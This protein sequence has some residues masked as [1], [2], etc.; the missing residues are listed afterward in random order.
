MPTPAS[1]GFELWA[2]ALE[3]ARG[4]AIAAPTHMANA[5][6]TIVGKLDEY[7]P[8]DQVGELAEAQ[9]EEIVRQSATFALEGAADVT[10]M[11][12]FANLLLDAKTT[13]ILA[14]GEVTGFT[15]LTGGSGY[16]TAP[17][18]ALTAPPA[19]GR[20]AVMTA[21]V[22]AGVV[23]ALTIVDPGQGYATAPT[24]TFTPTGG[25]SGA[26]V[27]ITISARATLANMWEFTRKLT[28]DTIKSATAWWGDPNVLAWKC[29]CAM[30]NSLKLTGDASGTD[31]VKV[32]LDGIAMFP[33]ELLSGSMPT[34]PAIL[35]GPVLV[36]GRM[37]L[38]L[39]NNS[40]A[41]FGTTAITGRVAGAEITIP[42]GVTPIYIAT[43]PLGGVTFDHV[44]RKRARP[45]MKFTI[46]IQDN[47]QTQLF[48]AGT[49]CK[50]RVRFNSATPIEGAGATAFYPFVEVDMMGKLNA[51]DWGDL[52]GA[53]RTATFTLGGVKCPQIASDVR[54]RIQN[55]S[56]VL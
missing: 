44:Q 3:A 41:P 35:L 21:T 51:L 20:Q 18:V 33:S 2:L 42:T 4:T 17:T 7:V 29:A 52:E 25:G 32:A 22:A 34:W 27:T 38:W 55:S 30:L 37:Q 56:G 54:M 9:R 26:S 13:G 12:V 48:I 45:E 11:P 36:P 16:T 39:E 5:T 47:A 28:S 10:K 43:G 23:T 49:T 14:G 15:G 53:S 40:T 50:V 24:A 19:G 8:P 46:E 6:G 1:L 31:G